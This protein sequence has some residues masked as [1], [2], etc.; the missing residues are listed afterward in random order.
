MNNSTTYSLK[1]MH[2]KW[3]EPNT[4]KLPQIMPREAEDTTMEV[5][6]FGY[7]EYN[8]KEVTSLCVCFCLSLCVCVSDQVSMLFS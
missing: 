6:T 4:Y 7:V 1:S 5:E 8:G 3:K 2:K